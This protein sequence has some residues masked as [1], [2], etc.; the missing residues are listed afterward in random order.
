MFWGTVA[1]FISTLAHAGSPPVLIHL[2]P[3]KLARD[4]FVGTNV[5]FFFIM[6]VVKLVPY[7]QLGLLRVGNLTAIVLLSPMAY[8]GVKLGVFLN[9][10]FSEVWFNRVIYFAL[11]LTAIQL[12]AGRSIIHFFFH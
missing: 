1:G 4:I 12:I 10:R 5:L 9:R 2:L 8:V 7:G 6:N 3:Q 11:T